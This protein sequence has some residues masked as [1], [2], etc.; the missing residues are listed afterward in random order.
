MVCV[1]RCVARC[2]YVPPWCDSSD[3]RSYYERGSFFGSVA[4]CSNGYSQSVRAS[5]SFVVICH[6]GRT[7]RRIFESLR[8][9]TRSLV[10]LV[11][12]MGK[13]APVRRSSPFRCMLRGKVRR[14]NM[15][16]VGTKKFPYTQAGIT[17]AKKFAFESGMM[18][19]MEN[20]KYMKRSKKRKK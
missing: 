2:V 6:S 13:R 4:H 19:K 17:A 11:E 7:S 3:S 15:P 8:R 16:M 5:F 1:T 18:M 9:T 10:R 14:N 12:Q 20:D